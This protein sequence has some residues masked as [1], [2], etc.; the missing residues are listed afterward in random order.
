MTINF[1]PPRT[2]RRSLIGIGAGS[3]MS[4]SVL[5]A[6]ALGNASNPFTQ[7]VASGDPSS[8]G[9]VLWTRLAP[10]PLAPDGL[11]GIVGEHPARWEVAN[12]EE[13]HVIVARGAATAADTF[14]HA[15]HVEVG[16][17]KPGRP[18]W[19]RFHARG[20]ESPVGRTRT[21]PHPGADLD[22]LRIA[23]VSCS[24]W[25]EGWFTAYSRIVDEDPDLVI[26]LGDYIYEYNNKGKKAE[27]RV[28]LH[29]GP[30]AT[31]L[32]SYRLRYSLYRTDPDLQRLHAAV[33]ALMTWDDHEVENDYA[34]QWSEHRDVEP[35][36]FL[37]RRRAAYQVFYENMPLRARSKPVAD[38]MRVYDRFRF[39]NLVE[40]PIL[41]GR[42]YR[43]RE[44]CPKGDFQGGH[45]VP[46]ICT[47]R[48]DP[49]RTML[50]LP[51]ERWL[52]EGFQRSEARWNIVAQ[53]LLIAA[54]LQQGTDGTV[55]H[56]T[57]GWDGYPACR[58]RMLDAVKASGMRNPVF[59]GGDIH[60]F[61]TTDLK[62]DFAKP[63]SE[64]VATEFV[65]GSI[66]AD[67]PPYEPFAAF[68]PRNPHVKF[69]DSR[70]HGYMTADI[71]P[72]SLTTRFRAVDRIQKDAPATTLAAFAVEDG[73]AGAVR[74]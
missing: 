22:R 38:R 25:E 68:L 64:T 1:A 13:M 65:G 28:R 55:G 45:V 54:L 56:W 59:F 53:D 26:F 16:G 49:A 18:Y 20:W 47:E 62:A 19:Y 2:S 61:W 43:D 33:P 37:A 70:A 6:W 10:D 58:A 35:H 66:S 29:V 48:S 27:G 60:S 40:M 71:T 21:L 36:T 46:E 51:Q 72:K 34:G 67:A 8:D 42:Q 32:A 39:G 57:D 73:K 30:E 52:F 69:F 11:G 44:A 23:F 4:A 63:E 31:D 74:L 12:D 14:N 24:N 3:L 15:L 7:G 50:G 9:F 41:D 5:P 17:L